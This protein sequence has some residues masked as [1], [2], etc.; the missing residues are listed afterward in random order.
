MNTNNISLRYSFYTISLLILILTLSMTSGCSYYDNQSTQS[1]QPVSL[2]DGQTRQFWSAVRPVSTLP[3]SHYKLGRYYQN[4]GKY[5]LAADE[6]I[7]AIKLD[8]SFIAAYNGLGMAYDA[9]LECD[10]AKQAYSLAVSY[11]PDIAYLHNNYGCSRI[12]CDDF[13][14][15][16][17]LLARAVELDAQSNRIKNNLRLAEARKLYGKPE[18]SLFPEKEISQKQIP[19][20][21][22]GSHL[23]V[24]RQPFDVNARKKT[25]EQSLQLT[26]NIQPPLFSKPVKIEETTN[27]TTA[28]IEEHNNTP[29]VAIA[30]IIEQQ[31]VTIP[32][33]FA[34]KKQ[35]PPQP[36]SD[37]SK[38]IVL[39]GVE[40]SNGNGITGM[41]G[42]SAT[43]FKS[44]GFSVNRITNA[45]SFGYKTSI[46]LYRDGCLELAKEIAKSVPGSQEFEKVVDLGRS[47]IG[48][49]LVLGSDLKS[50]HFPEGL[51]STI[52][53]RQAIDTNALPEIASN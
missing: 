44:L 10:K 22:Q 1:L 45:P 34:P 18:L 28:R 24:W 52:Q 9:L 15:A 48:V 21:H 47:G 11:G 25:D 17:D 20:P 3:T 35:K 8:N 37:T 14:L 33:I 40:I 7:K 31:Q 5:K 27:Q 30:P 43:F 12:L 39:S 13:D 41:A 42:R 36:A 6:F 16:V 23:V 4:R 26:K 38:N 29:P 32:T 50:M 49:R 46:I 19:E 2:K 53:K 51:A